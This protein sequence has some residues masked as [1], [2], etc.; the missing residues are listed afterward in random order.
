M[1]SI[2]FSDSRV[3]GLYYTQRRRGCFSIAGEPII[4]ATPVFF[5][6]VTNPISYLATGRLSLLL[7]LQTNKSRTICTRV[8][9]LTRR[10]I[11]CAQWP[12]RNAF[13]RRAVYQV[14]ITF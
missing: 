12:G 10:L 4:N 5:S 11:A 14:F 6:H 8:R 7:G 3:R 13:I 2:I 1:K 9:L